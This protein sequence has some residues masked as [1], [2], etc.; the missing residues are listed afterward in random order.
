MPI[1]QIYQFVRV[2]LCA[3]MI[4][5]LPAYAFGS[6]AMAKCPDLTSDASVYAD[7]PRGEFKPFAQRWAAGRILRCQAPVAALG[8]QWT[9]AQR[10][11][12]RSVEL[13]G[14]DRS[15]T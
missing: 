7:A 15:E 12:E 10:R 14:N 9:P 8:V 1:R 5:G 6:G 2:E 13:F 11:P 3:E 4:G